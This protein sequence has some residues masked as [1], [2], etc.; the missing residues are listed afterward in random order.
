[1]FDNS[2]EAFKWNKANEVF[3][4]CVNGLNVA[5]FKSLTQLFSSSFVITDGLSGKVHHILQVGIAPN[6]ELAQLNIR[7]KIF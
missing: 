2:L 4:G 6:F 5:K 1:M 7:G 3:Q